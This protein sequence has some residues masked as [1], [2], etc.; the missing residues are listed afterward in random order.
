MAAGTTR[1]PRR[2]FRRLTREV[3]VGEVGIG[4]TNPIRLQS[5]TTTDTLDTI[6]TVD[7]CERLVNAGCEILRITAPSLKGRRTCRRSRGC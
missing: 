1:D 2:P 5:M 4:G 3:R 7:Q 6:A